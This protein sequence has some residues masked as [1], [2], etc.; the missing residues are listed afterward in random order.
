M[1]SPQDAAS[2]CQICGKGHLDPGGGFRGYATKAD[3][4]ALSEGSSEASFS[5][6]A[7]PLLK[8]MRAA[9]FSASLVDAEDV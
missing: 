7:S 6:S 1:Q 2:R 4:S 8:E 9:G 3:S 5:I